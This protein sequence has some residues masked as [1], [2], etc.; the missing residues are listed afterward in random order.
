MIKKVSVFK[1]KM[2]CPQKPQ[3]YTMFLWSNINSKVLDY[4]KEVRGWKE[5]DSFPR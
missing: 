4:Q 1:Y 3:I 2:Q 5:K